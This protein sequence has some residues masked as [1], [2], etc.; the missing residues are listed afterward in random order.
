LRHGRRERRQQ[1]RENRDP[2]GDTAGACGEPHF[3]SC[4]RINACVRVPSCS[5]RWPTA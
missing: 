2:G 3:L 5:A 4:R 1:D